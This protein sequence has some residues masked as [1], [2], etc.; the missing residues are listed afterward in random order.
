MENPPTLDSSIGFVPSFG[1]LAVAAAAAAAA[2]AEESA[3]TV[4]SCISP[5][6]SVYR[7]S[8]SGVPS[9]E[10]KFAAVHLPG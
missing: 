7:L 6:Y 5:E 1:Y 10:G 9:V 8:R 2:A 3:L 4:D